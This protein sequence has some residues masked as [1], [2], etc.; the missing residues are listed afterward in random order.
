[1]KPLERVQ[2]E[3]VKLLMEKYNGKQA[4]V[5]KELEITSC[6][7][8]QMLARW[9]MRPVDKGERRSKRCPERMKDEI[10]AMKRALITAGGISKL[11]ADL[12]GMN[13]D[14]FYAK[15]RKH[16]LHNYCIDQRP[17][18]SGNRHRRI[19]PEPIWDDEN[20]VWIQPPDLYRGSGEGRGANAE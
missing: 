6:S 18:N 1:M 15:I 4:K 20:S 17:L 8:N 12:I 2:M 5:A 3:F 19:V 9:E 7:L 13:R 14:T 10:Q 16:R 11:A